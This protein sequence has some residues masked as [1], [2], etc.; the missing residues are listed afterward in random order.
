MCVYDRGRGERRGEINLEEEEKGEIERESALLVC[1]FAIMYSSN[2][3]PQ[4]S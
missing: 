3:K 2:T 4:D 1:L